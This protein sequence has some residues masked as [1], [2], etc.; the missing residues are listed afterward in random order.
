M[1]DHRKEAAIRAFWSEHPLIAAYQSTKRT[2]SVPLRDLIRFVQAMP[3]DE[4]ER[5]TQQHS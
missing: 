4:F 3:T 2:A 1:T 5:C